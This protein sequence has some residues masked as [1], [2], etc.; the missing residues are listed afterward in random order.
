LLEGEI[1]L[2]LR[3][4]SR[5]E[6]HELTAWFAIGDLE[7]GL[8]KAI[9]HKFSMTVFHV[10]NSCSSDFPKGALWGLRAQMTFLTINDG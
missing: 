2:A 3:I 8:S 10:R 7:G 4:L 9:T 6:V 1:N 5:L